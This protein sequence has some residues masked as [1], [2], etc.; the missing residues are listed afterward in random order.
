M[1]YAEGTKVPT[2]RTRGEIEA[3]VEQHGASKFMSMRDDDLHLAK[4]S[5]AI[6]GLLIR[7][8]L[9]LPDADEMR[10][11]LKKQKYWQ[12]RAI[13]EDRLGKELDTETRRRWRC[14]LL[15]IKAKLISVEDKV[16]TFEEAFLAHIVT[17]EDVTIYERMK[18]EGGG[19]LLLGPAGK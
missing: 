12:G 10:K 8:T 15:T 3:L 9:H 19:Q 2:S 17:A 5:F 11:L 4:I 7:F 1:A 14:L 16:E 18:I 6:K 13:G